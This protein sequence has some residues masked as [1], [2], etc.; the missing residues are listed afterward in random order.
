MCLIGLRKVVAGATSSKLL[1]S[2]EKRS[3]PTW[4]GNTGVLVPCTIACTAMGMNGV[5]VAAL[6]S[7]A[8]GDGVMTKKVGVS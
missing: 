8:A 4:M 7:V 6:V 2:V 1:M 5:P 3:R